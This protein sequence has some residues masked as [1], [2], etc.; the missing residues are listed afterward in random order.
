M[1]PEYLRYRK[2]MIS[3]GKDFV[4]LGQW[5]KTQAAKP[6]KKKKSSGPCFI[7]GVSF[8]GGQR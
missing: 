2:R 6:A 7:A 3:Q 5:Q 4:S 8:G 1:N